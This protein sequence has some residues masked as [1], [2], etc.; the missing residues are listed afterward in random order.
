M[1]KSKIVFFVLTII[2]I[3][4]SMVYSAAVTRITAEQ[5]AMNWYS[6]RNDKSPNDFQIIESFI[7]KENTENIYFIFNFDKTGFVMVS[8]DDAAIPI[9]GY[10]FEHNY[11][12]ENHP[13]QFDAMLASFKEQ[14]VYAKEN[15]LSASKE[16]QDEWERLN[17]RKENFERNRDFSRLGPLLSTTWDQGLYY[18]EMCPPDGASTAGNGYVWA[19]CTATATSQVMKYHAH[20]TTGEGS[21]SYLCSPYGNLSANFGATTYN[22]TLMPNSVTSLNIY[23]QTLLYHVGVGA[24]MQY[25]PTGS[26]AWIGG[27]HPATALSALKDHFRYNP[28]AYYALKASYTN[29]VWHGMLKTEL[30]NN[31]PLV[32]AGYDPGGGGGHAFVLDG[33]D[34]TINTYYHFNWGWSGAYDGYFYLT[35]LNPGGSNFTSDQEALFDVEP[36]KWRPLP[37]VSIDVSLLPYTGVDLDNY[38]EVS[39]TSYSVVTDLS[40]QEFALTINTNN[41]LVFTENPTV[42]SDVNIDITI[43]ATY[44]SGTADDTFNFIITGTSSGSTV[45]W[46][47]LP[48]LSPTGMDVDATFQPEDPGSPPIILADDFL[49]TETGNITDIHI[50]GSWKNDEMP[51]WECPEAVQFTFSIHSDI[52]ASMSPTGYSMPGET[53]WM[54][55]WYPMYEDVEWIESGV[56]DWYNPDTGEWINDNHLWC[57]KYNCILDPQDYFLQEGTPEDPIVYWLDVQAVPQDP[58]MPWVR[59]GWKTSY[60][61]WN[62]DAV[63]TIGNEPYL[64]DWNELIYP[65]GHEYTGESIDLAFQI[66]TEEGPTDEYDFGDA[67]DPTYPTLLAIGARHIIDYQIFMGTSIDAELDGQP[68]AAATGDDLAGIDDEDGVNFLNPL[69]IGQPVNVD[70]TVS[71]D[72]FINAWIDFDIDGGWAE[73][74]DQIFSDISVSAGTNTLNFIVPASASL[75]TSFARFRFNTTGGLT[76]TGLANDGEVED[77]RVTIEEE[78]TYEYDF[79]D[80]PEGDGAIAYPSSGVTGL[81]PTCITVGPSGF[82]SHGPGPLSAYFGPSVDLEFDGNAGACPGCFPAYDLDECFNDGDAGLIIPEPFTIDAANTVVPC[83]GYLGTPL[84]TICQTATWGVDIDIDVQNLSTLDLFVNVLFDWNQNGYWLDDSGTTCLGTMTPEHVLVN[85]VVPAGYSGP[86]SGLTPPSFVIGPNAGYFWSRFTISDLP[87]PA[88]EWNGEGE[89]AEGETEDYLILVEEEPEELDFGDAPDPTYPTLSIRT[90]ANHIIDGVTFLGASVDAEP[91][92]QPDATATG[93]DND[94]NDDEDGIIFNQIMTGSPA[95]IIVTTSTS[96]YLQGWMDFNADGDWTDLNEQIF[97][98]LY[99]HFAG[100][101][102]LNYYV[103]ATAT[104]GNTFARF[105]FDTNGGLGITGQASDGEVEDYSVDIVEDPDVKW[106]QLPCE[107]LSGLHCHDHIIDPDPYNSIIIADDWLCNGGLVTDIHWW[108]CYEAVNSGINDFHL[109]IHADDPTGTCLPVDPELWGINVPLSQVNETPTGIF[110][111]AGN[112]IYSYDYVLT[113]PFEQTEGQYYWLDITAH[114]IDPLNYVIWNWQESS[115]SIA[116]ILCTAADKTLTTPWQHIDWATPPP[117]RFTD[118]AFEITSCLPSAPLNFTISKVGTNITLQWDPD[119]CSIYYNV[120]SSTDPYATFPG[121]WTL[122]AYHITATTWNDPVSTAGSK[123]FYR[124]TAEN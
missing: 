103:P 104:I 38:C 58:E 5:V 64:G 35:S 121:G 36:R 34:S 29:P 97:T 109:S 115:R 8:A 3:I 48:D 45:K 89:F 86:L 91:D 79:G 20:P 17:V 53:L 106:S 2:L 33:Y 18:N 55:T 32:Y 81:F 54:K 107:E 57:F 94:G 85:F 12:L 30:D 59:F 62:D 83:T 39:A 52:P 74:N 15:N 47:Q 10:V 82:V 87:V 99:I 26:G 90:G 120:Y 22:W 72:G 92:G 118:M 105:R 77:Y 88:G 114:S 100:T 119:P 102:C 1:K 117:T 51:Y 96:G 9:L 41:E 60:E 61:H 6:E 56:E 40:G 76:Y 46:E 44:S 123:K 112:M 78:V 122:E 23:V 42:T 69:Y 25:G 67:P 13:P 95:Q 108:G 7:E 110:N 16:A 21:H 11:T 50:W 66:T 19:G 27:A 14:I 4:P 28:N 65:F 37:D 43:R 98:D 70:V 63:W 111:S 75:G 93:D 73:V 116:P 49:C 68:D 31:R 113:S 71:V 101:V 24:E 80:A 84:G 124:V